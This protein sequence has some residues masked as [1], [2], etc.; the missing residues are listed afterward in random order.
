MNSPD[1]MRFF[2]LSASYR[3]SMI[4]IRK[5]C[6]SGSEAGAGESGLLSGGVGNAVDSLLCGLTALSGVKVHLPNAQLRMYC[7]GCACCSA[8]AVGIL[9]SDEGGGFEAVKIALIR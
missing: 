5:I 8:R 1:S 7:T 4:V 6:V 3:A 9:S 2:H